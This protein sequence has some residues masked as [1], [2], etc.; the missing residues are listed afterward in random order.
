[1]ANECMGTFSKIRIRDVKKASRDY[2]VFLLSFPVAYCSTTTNSLSRL[3]VEVIV[4]R[5]LQVIV[6]LLSVKKGFS[7][8][9]I[10]ICWT[11][12]S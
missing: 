11:S 10:F 2:L 3:S 12:G 9:Q 7:K 5:L 1:M 4:I 6:P 8:D